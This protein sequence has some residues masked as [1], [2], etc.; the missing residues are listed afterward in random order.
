MTLK[1]MSTL[2]Y[3]PKQQQQTNKSANNKKNK[4]TNTQ[5]NKQKQTNKA[6]IMSLTQP[7]EQASTIESWVW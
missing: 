7:L 4:Q 5:T 6:V 2:V 1:Y 3:P